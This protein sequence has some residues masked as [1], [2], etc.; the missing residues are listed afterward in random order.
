[1]RRICAN[2]HKKEVA[3]EEQKAD[4]V[5]YIHPNGKTIPSG[6]QVT[7]SKREMPQRGL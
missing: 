6:T 3:E 5:P 4:Y 1:M 7:Q 2:K